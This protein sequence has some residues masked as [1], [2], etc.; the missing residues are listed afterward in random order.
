MLRIFFLCALVVLFQNLMENDTPKKLLFALLENIPEP[1]PSIST[2]V[3]GKNWFCIIQSSSHI[4]F[5][6]PVLLG[7]EA[8]KKEGSGKQR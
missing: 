8:R 6:L 3:G 2:E 4:E 5:K 1:T 7:E